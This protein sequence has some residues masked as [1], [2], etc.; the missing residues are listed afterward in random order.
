M[1]LG[2]EREIARAVVN[3]IAAARGLPAPW[4]EVAAE[5]PAWLAGEDLAGWGVAELGALRERLLD[6]K[7]RESGGVW[8]TPPE[9][10][11]F[12]T[13]FSL[14]PVIDR[15]ADASDPESALMVLAVDPSCGAGVFLVSAARLIAR[16][17]A[18]LIAKAEPTE[19]MI[20]HVMPE[21][22]S[23]C[24]FGIDID[25]VAV[26]LAKSALWLE[27]DGAEPITFMDRN[28]ICGNPLNNDIPPKLEELYGAPVDLA[29]EAS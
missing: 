8:Y 1:N 20:R 5:L 6:S 18:A 3:G 4:P 14:N 23:E 7:E 10:A 17:Y 26:D 29:A 15:L 9:V 16:R 2:G 11:D 22:M 21:V 27:I 24:L 12:M 25:P 28:V 13:G 19:W